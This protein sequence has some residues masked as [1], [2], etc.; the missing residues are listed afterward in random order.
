[1]RQIIARLLAIISLLLCYDVAAQSNLARS[2]QTSS[3]SFGGPL[4]RAIDGEF[5][6]DGAAWNNSAAITAD[7]GDANLILDLGKPATIALILLQSDG[8]D[9]Y[10]VDISLDQTAWI[11]IWHAAPSDNPD[12]LRRRA[13][14]LEAPLQARYVRVRAGENDGLI[15]ISE[16]QLYEKRPTNGGEIS[17]PGPSS[18]PWQWSRALTFESI[19][20][21]KALVA[22]LALIVL[23]ANAL[24]RAVDRD[25]RDL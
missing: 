21:I 3:L 18:T 19:A 24:L 2:G 16:L 17:T 5:A 4:N 12:G 22:T 14:E 20:R 23:I 13:I 9:T 7:N 1:M 25:G 11:P 15:S 6:P 10:I 8:N